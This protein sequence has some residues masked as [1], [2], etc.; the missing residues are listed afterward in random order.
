MAGGLIER[1]REPQHSSATS[2]GPLDVDTRLA[3]PSVSVPVLSMTR[4][5]A[6]AR[7]SSTGPPFTSTPRCAALLIPEMIATGTA[8]ISGHGVAEISTA[9]NRR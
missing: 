4:L 7:V 8:R 3:R 5:V 9:R 1:G 2:A 6:R